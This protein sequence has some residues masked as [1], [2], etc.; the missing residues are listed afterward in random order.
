MVQWLVHRGVTSIS[1]T[2]DAFFETKAAVVLAEKALTK[3]TNGNSSG[4]AS[5]KVCATGNNRGEGVGTRE[6]RGAVAATARS[7]NNDTNNN[8]RSS[9][10]SSGGGRARDSGSS[11]KSS[12]IV[13]PSTIYPKVQIAGGRGENSNNGGGKTK[14]SYPFAK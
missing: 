9:S 5:D 1:V 8:N 6:P 10:S 7:S 14:S 13:D 12:T 3:T 4:S 11:D 2:P